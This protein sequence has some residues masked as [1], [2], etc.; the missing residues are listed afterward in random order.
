MRCRA[1]HY[2]DFISAT[3]DSTRIALSSLARCSGDESDPMEQKHPSIITPVRQVVQ[4]RSG[5]ADPR[6]AVDE[7]AE[8]CLRFTHLKL[9]QLS[10]G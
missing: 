9:K 7:T 10:N 4:R 5:R 8:G 3:V 6:R 2:D 1:R